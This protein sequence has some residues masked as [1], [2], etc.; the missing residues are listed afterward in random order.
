MGCMQARSL[1]LV[2]LF[3]ATSLPLHAGN[4]TQPGTTAQ[5]PSLLQHVAELSVRQYMLADAD[6]SAQ[7]ARYHKQSKR[8]ARDEL[9]EIQSTILQRQ[10]LRRMDVH[11]TPD[12][13]PIEAL[14]RTFIER[15]DAVRR[16]GRCGAASPLPS[17]DEPGDRTPR[18]VDVYCEFADIALSPQ[19]FHPGLSRHERMEMQI[20]AAEVALASKP[21]RRMEGT[22]TL[23]WDARGGVWRADR[24]SMF[25]FTRGVMRKMF[26]D[27]ERDALKLTRYSYHADD[28]RGVAAQDMAQL[29]LDSAVHRDKARFLELAT[30]RTVEIDEARLAPSITWEALPDVQRRR[31]HS[32]AE[33]LPW[34]GYGP[35]ELLGHLAPLAFAARCKALAK[36]WV[37]L[38]SYRHPTVK[39][40][41]VCA[42]RLPAVLSSH[43]L[44]GLRALPPDQRMQTLIE[45]YAQAPTHGRD[46]NVLTTLLLVPMGDRWTLPEPIENHTVALALLLAERAKEDVES[47][48][49]SYSPCD[50]HCHPQPRSVAPPST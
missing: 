5:P 43:D 33:A 50:S 41:A 19:A 25:T 29:V 10:E 14:R 44:V 20:R 38:D 45:R 8:E 39:V 2:A 18:D 9:D 40:A 17:A 16:N 30:Y 26:T 37:S 12:A 7:L 11:R 31:M 15:L 35:E 1:A 3:A 28:M 23:E 48:F 46:F 47:L 32:N 49:G 24:V 42:V 34:E 22:V 4:R 21:T 6:S 13:P 27:T 36:Q